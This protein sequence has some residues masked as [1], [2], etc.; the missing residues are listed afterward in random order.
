M[1]SLPAI[2]LSFAHATLLALLVVPSVQAAAAPVAAKGEAKKEQVSKDSAAA[3]GGGGPAVKSDSERGAD[4]KK[5]V[6]APG[7]RREAKL[8]EGYGRDGEEEQEYQ[9]LSDALRE[10]EEQGKEYRKEIQL[11]IE[12]KYEEKRKGLEASYE[13]AISDIEVLE[14]KE[15]LDAI[16]MFEE[17]LQRYPDDPKYTPDVMFRLAELY[18][19]KTKDDY[20]IAMKEYEEQVRLVDQGKLAAAPPE[21]KQSFQRSVDLY[22][23][24]ITRFP[25]YRFNDA[26]YYLLGFCLEK[27]GE[28]EQSSDT[29]TRL[30]EKF[31]GSRFV[32]EA[33]VRLG[34]YY[35][36]A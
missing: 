31:Q 8:L 18:Y 22:Q 24:L 20:A 34:E 16:A 21:P 7:E 32:P 6:V 35:F 29:F 13:K 33:W 25:S 11:L 10:F 3:Q 2:A 5:E 1:R 15:R 27:Q 36:D 30:I 17:F 9:E 4:E 26:S 14:R 28:L 19:E 12:K 23:Q